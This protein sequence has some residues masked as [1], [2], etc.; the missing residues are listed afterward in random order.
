MQSAFG[1]CYLPHYA[2]RI[3]PQKHPADYPVHSLQATPK[4]KVETE[5]FLY[6]RR[7]AANSERDQLNTQHSFPGDLLEGG[8]APGG[9]VAK[10]TRRP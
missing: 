8:E 6:L 9:L 5:T 4:P 1:V 3:W 7:L 2:R 10:V